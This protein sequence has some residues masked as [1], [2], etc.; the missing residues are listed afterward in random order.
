MGAQLEISDG[1][2]HKTK[3]PPSFPGRLSEFEHKYL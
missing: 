1:M 2:I 3:S